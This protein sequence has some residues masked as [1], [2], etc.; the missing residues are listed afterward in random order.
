VPPYLQLAVS[1]HTHLH[2]SFYLLSVYMYTCI[3]VSNH[4]CMSIFIYIGSMWRGSVSILSL[5]V[6]L[7]HTYTR[8]L[9]HAL[10]FSLS[11][12]VRA[13]V[14]G[15]CVCMWGVNITGAREIDHCPYSLSLSFSLSLSL[16]MYMCACAWCV[17]VYGV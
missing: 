10:S 17:H 11:V 16:S 13:S 7:A 1:I 2:L 15:M 8:T 6:S 3:H 5:Y 12:H 9:C 14:H 4:T